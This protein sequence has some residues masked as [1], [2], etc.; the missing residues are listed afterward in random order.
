MAVLTKS[1]DEIAG[2]PKRAWRRSETVEEVQRLNYCR[3]KGRLAE[4]APAATA[5]A[6]APTADPNAAN[7]KVKK[8]SGAE[9]AHKSS[10]TSISELIV[11]A[12]STSKERSGMSLAALKK[13]LAASGN[14]VEKHNTCLKQAVKSLVSKG[15]LLQT[16]GSGASASFKKQP[17]SKKNSTPKSKKPAMKKQKKAASAGVKESPKR[18][19]KPS[20]AATKKSCQA[21]QKTESG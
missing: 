20:A 13:A 14:D 10:G 1:C 5:S 15:T 11:N 17:E 21:P 4:T 9:K 3:T 12:I 2:S 8:P 18:P 19:K 6:A 7:K 16:K